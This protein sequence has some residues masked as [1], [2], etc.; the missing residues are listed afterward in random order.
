[1]NLLYMLLL[2]DSRDRISSSI[3][4]SNFSIVLNVPITNVK[5][6]KLQKVLMN[7]KIYNISSE[8]SNNTISYT[9]KSLPTFEEPPVAQ[10]T[11][12]VTA[13]LATGYYSIADICYEVAQQMT[14]SSHYGYM[15]TVTYNYK[16]GKFTI[17]CSGLFI[18]PVSTLGDYLGFTT[19]ITSYVNEDEGYTA[20][21][22]SKINDP[23]YYY[24]SIN[25]LQS[26]QS[27]RNNIISTFMITNNEEQTEYQSISEQYVCINDTITLKEIQVYLK[28]RDGS[29]VQMNGSNFAL[30]LNVITD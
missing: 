26:L 20:D 28:N 13:T 21:S 11:H 22:V 12:T 23:V 1:M 19:A 30:L 16:T 2:L 4:S 8:Y 9:E 17:S 25:N 24:I 5:Y 10:T 27:G 7:H 14:N 15:Y 29:S 3:S 18:L 6:I